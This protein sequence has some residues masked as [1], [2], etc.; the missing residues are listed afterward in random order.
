MA[1]ETV[2]DVPIYRGVARELAG[3]IRGG[4]LLPGSRVPSER[5]LAGE[6]GI[7]RMTARA[8]LNL[9]EQRGLIE[10]RDRSGTFVAS[11][12]IALDLSAVAGLSARLLRQGITPGAEVVERRTAAAGDLEGAVAEAL[13]IAGE[14]PLHVVVRRRTG[15]GEPL[16]LE[17]SYFPARYCAGLLD[18]DLTGSIY[19][20]LRDEYGLEPVRLYQEVEVTQLDTVA[21]VKLDVRPDVPVLLVTRT[22][23]DGGGRPIEFARDLYRGDRLL[24]VAETEGVGEEQKGGL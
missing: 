2:G 11:P 12:K 22:A 18:N 19:E 7:S 4:D 20:L 13:D 6:Y 9:L 8:A 3:L 10:R 23:W 24:F 16:A 21:A 1:N 5:E 15:N 17:E 14:E